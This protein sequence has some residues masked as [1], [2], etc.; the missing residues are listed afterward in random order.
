MI[1]LIFIIPYEELCPFAEEVPSE[2]KSDEEIVTSTFVLKSWEGGGFSLLQFCGKDD[3][4]M[5]IENG[6]SKNTVFSKI[7]SCDMM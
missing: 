2:Y 3:H 6:K 4:V 5:M 1:H 7:I